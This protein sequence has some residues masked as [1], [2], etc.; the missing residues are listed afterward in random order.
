MTTLTIIAVSTAILFAI[1]A[2][3]IRVNSERNARRAEEIAE[4]N[5]EEA[6]RHSL[7]IGRAIGRYQ[8]FCLE[9]NEREIARFKA[10]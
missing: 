6:E 3:V 2:H 9:Q 4:W 7:E 1:R 5:L 10:E 8:E